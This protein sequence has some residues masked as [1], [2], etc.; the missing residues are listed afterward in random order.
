MLWYIFSKKRI[1][2]FGKFWIS[3]FEYISGQNWPSRNLEIV[4]NFMLANTTKISEIQ[5][6]FGTSWFLDVDKTDKFEEYD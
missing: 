1:S 5:N 6:Y 4:A 2:K 3:L